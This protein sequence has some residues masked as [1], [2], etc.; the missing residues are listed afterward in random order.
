MGYYTNY[1]LSYER[2]HLATSEEQY[3]KSLQEFLNKHSDYWKMTWK[4]VV[5]GNLDSRKWYDHDDDMI[6]L[7]KE[8]PELL[9]ALKGEGEE[10]GDI[11]KTYYLNGKMQHCKAKIIFDDFSLDKLV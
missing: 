6:K 3:W 9:F 1:S 5:K 8:H 10:S 4:E 11:W 7:S 2:S